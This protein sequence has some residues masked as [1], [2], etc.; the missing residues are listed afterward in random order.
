MIEFMPPPKRRRSQN[1]IPSA[2]P[3]GAA[4]LAFSRAALAEFKKLP[5]KVQM[6]LRRKLLDFGITPAIGKPLVGSLK[7]YHR[8]TYGR[9]RTIATVSEKA[10]DGAMVVVALHIGLRKEGSQNDPYEVAA[11]KALKG[12]DAEARAALEAE[13]H[14]ALQE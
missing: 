2:A 3:K 13:I 9:L 4:R 8:V 6:G 5:E 14:Q 1:P 12:D 11:A 7:G 10:A